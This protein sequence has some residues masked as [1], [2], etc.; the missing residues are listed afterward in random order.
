MPNPAHEPLLLWIVNNW[1]VAEQLLRAK[2]ERLDPKND[3]LILDVRT[4]RGVS[5]SSLDHTAIFND[6]RVAELTAIRQ[7]LGS[8][9]FLYNRPWCKTLAQHVKKHVNEQRGKA[10]VCCL[11]AYGDAA[12]HAPDQ[13]DPKADFDMNVASYFVS[14][15]EKIAEASVK[16]LRRQQLE[17]LVAQHRAAQQ[18]SAAA[19][20]EPSSSSTCSGTETMRE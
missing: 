5:V 16:Q 6:A 19:G 12:E 9:P 4:K 8:H 15:L 13:D 14:D 20:A 3:L 17:A 10:G 18:Q 11:F 1:T 7:T 2:T